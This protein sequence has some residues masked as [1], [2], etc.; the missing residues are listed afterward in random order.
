VHKSRRPRQLAGSLCPNPLL[1]DGRALDAAL[2]TGFA[3]ITAAAITPT[4]RVLFAACGAAVHTADPGSRL[5]AWLQRGHAEAAIV[6]PD[7]T[8][9]RAGTIAE[10]RAALRH[11]C[12]GAAPLPNPQV[13]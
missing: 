4:D 2:G 5:A 8:V 12:G 7:R 3:L 11:H 10:L 9:M 6:R 13:V 1:P